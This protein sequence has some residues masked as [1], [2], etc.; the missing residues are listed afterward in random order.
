M[1]RRTGKPKAKP[2]KLPKP[3][4]VGPLDVQ[5]RYSRAEAAAYLKTSLPTIHKLINA[6]LLEAYKEGS[7]TFVTGRGIAARSLPPT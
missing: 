6:G 5:Q 4:V 1:K 7:R 3:V 2:R